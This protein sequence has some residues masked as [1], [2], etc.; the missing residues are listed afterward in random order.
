MVPG[1]PLYV[2]FKIR[3]IKMRFFSKEPRMLLAIA[4]LKRSN[5][6]RG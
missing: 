4:A 5:W 2:I 1:P 3:T 6:K